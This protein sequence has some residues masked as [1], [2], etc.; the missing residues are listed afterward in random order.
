VSRLAVL[1]RPVFGLGKRLSINLQTMRE[2]LIEVWTE[3]LVNR[4]CMESEN[5][6]PMQWAF[7]VRP[8][9]YAGSI[10]IQEAPD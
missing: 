2:A 10:N 7:C 8:G 4:G 3:E 1:S 5:F 9:Q 6:I